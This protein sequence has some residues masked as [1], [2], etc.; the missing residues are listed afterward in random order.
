[1]NDSINGIQAQY[2]MREKEDLIETLKQREMAISV[3]RSENE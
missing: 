1:M 2:I 3:L